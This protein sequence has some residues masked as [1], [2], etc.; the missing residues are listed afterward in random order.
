MFKLKLP[1]L[2][3]VL[4]GLTALLSLPPALASSGPVGELTPG[5]FAVGFEAVELFDHSRTFVD[6][7][8]YDGNLRPVETSR[9]VRPASSLL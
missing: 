1:V 5:Q 3:C 6:K 2:C 9:Q 7:Y 4:T 8:D